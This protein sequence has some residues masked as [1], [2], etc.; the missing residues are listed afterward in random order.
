MC[1]LTSHAWQFGVEPRVVV[2]SQ[3]RHR[4]GLQ[5]VILATWVLTLWT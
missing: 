3:M 1:S 2:V 5:L 4:I